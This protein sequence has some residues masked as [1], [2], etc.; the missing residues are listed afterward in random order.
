MTT[1]LRLSADGTVTDATPCASNALASRVERSRRVGALMS[2]VTADGALVVVERQPVGRQLRCRA[3]SDP[4]DRPAV[5]T[6]TRCAP[7]RARARW[8][9]A[10]PWT[11]RSAPWPTQS[12]RPAAWRRPPRSAGRRAY[13]PGGRSGRTPIAF[14]RRVR[15]RRARP[16]NG[17]GPRSW[18]STK[19]T[20]V[21]L[22]RGRDHG[23]DC[24]LELHRIE[25]DVLQLRDVHAPLGRHVAAGAGIRRG[26]RRPRARQRRAPPTGRSSARRRRAA[27]GA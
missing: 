25:H 11:R 9:S 15:L 3:A 12:Q 8:R 18:P 10:G 16:V 4:R 21:R 19:T 14:R 27:R 5:R 22:G 17:A 26:A 2:A 20:R 13:P 24:R 23:A 7:V 1:R 6:A